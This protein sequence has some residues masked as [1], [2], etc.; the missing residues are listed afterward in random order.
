MS[1]SVEWVVQ[2]SPE[3]YACV[4]SRSKEIKN[5]NPPSRETT[6]QDR[7]RFGRFELRP[8]ERRLLRDGEPV[9]LG[10]RAFDVL[11]ALAQHPDRLLTKGELMDLAWPGLVVEEANVQVQ[12]SALRKLLGS[13]AIAT[14]PGLGYRFSATLET[15]GETAHA[16]DANRDVVDN[17]GDPPLPAKP[18]VAVLPFANMSVDPEQGYFADGVTE[19]IITAL[20]RFHSLFVIAHSS[21]VTY[22]GK[23]TDVRT[24]ASQL[25][26][27]YVVEGSVRRAGDRIRVTARLIDGSTRRH[28]WAEHFDSKL[29]DVFAVQEQVTQSIVAAIAPGV[30]TAE[31]SNARRRRPASLSAYEIAVRAWADCSTS[32][33]NGDTT[34]LEAI[35]S[36]ARRALLI[37]AQSTLALNTVAGAQWLQVFFRSTPSL[38]ETWREGLDAARRACE[39][40]GSD[41]LGYVIKAL[42]LSHAPHEEG[43]AIAYD[44]AL[45]D[46]RT[47]HQLNPND[48]F[49]LRVLGHTEAVSGEPLKG[50]AHLLEA[51]RLNP[52]DPSSTNVYAMLS[53]AHFFARSYDE[54]VRW[55]LLAATQAPTMPNVRLF[56]AMNYV[57]AGDIAKAMASWASARSLA[58]DHVEVRTNGF[59]VFREPEDRLR[60]KVFLRIAAGLE[61]PHSADG[62][63]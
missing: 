47:A 42:L 9:P 54:G 25:G 44:E 15:A 60:Q 33:R 61:S 4:L 28:L 48:H 49:A 35:V 27:R 46:L 14:I 17:L 11:L 41:S 50:I 30:E 19:D 32:Y 56:L 43:G 16:S 18:S 6:V 40:D 37:D 52:R 13:Q 5:V 7:L 57:G 22:R 31:V 1:C 59:S 62:I 55:G 51:L 36:E 34:R 29:D 3:R 63:R 45:N 21:S 53:L 20:S 12:V 58:P 24:I 26:V 39:V 23:G 38:E 10:S 8:V 2:I